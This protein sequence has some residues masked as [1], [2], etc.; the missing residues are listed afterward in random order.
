MEKKKERERKTTINILAADVN[1]KIS[2]FG[3]LGKI[4]AAW[5][6]EKWEDQGKDTHMTD[7]FRTILATSLERLKQ[8]E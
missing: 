6:G 1:K 2:T 4:L 3:F 7:S 5:S 8:I